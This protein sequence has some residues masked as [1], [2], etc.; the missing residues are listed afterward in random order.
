MAD[1]PLLQ[2]NANDVSLL[3]TFSKAR[4]QV[5]SAIQ[6]AIVN[7]LVTE[8][9]SASATATTAIDAAIA[10]AAA[11]IVTALQA[12]FPRVTG[13]FTL[14]AATTKVVTE[15]HTTAS[16]VIMIMPTN[17]SAATLMGSSKSLYISA[18]SAGASFTVHTGD[19]TNAASGETFNYIMVG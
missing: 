10:A 3:G 4:N 18:L 6:Q 9:G 1:N 5:L 11:S 14:S 15:T 13:N 12:T 8:I 7:T 16:S 2:S 17:A 19:N